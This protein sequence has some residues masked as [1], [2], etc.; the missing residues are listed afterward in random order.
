MGNVFGGQGKESGLGFFIEIR[1]WARVTVCAHEQ[2]LPWTYYS[3]AS[4]KGRNTQA[5]LALCTDVGYKE[6]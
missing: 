4:I 1:G 6:E 3:L 2:E 5:F